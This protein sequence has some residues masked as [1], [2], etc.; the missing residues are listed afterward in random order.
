MVIHE[1]ITFDKLKKLSASKLLKSWPKRI[2][3]N[4][5]PIAVLMS[6][7]VYVAMTKN[8][9]EQVLEEE[10]TNN[11]IQKPLLQALPEPSPTYEKQQEIEEQWY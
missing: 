2:I 1:M 9:N 3:A 7:T 5:Q 6:P 8:R 4:N 10:N 11:S